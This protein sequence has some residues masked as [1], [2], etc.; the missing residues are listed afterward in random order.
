M[1]TCREAE[2]AE[3]GRGV[4]IIQGCVQGERETGRGQRIR[5]ACR[6]QAELSEVLK[7]IFQCVLKF[8]LRNYDQ[9]SSS[10]VGGG[11]GGSGGRRGREWEGESGGTRGR[12]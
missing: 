9:V 10:R 4:Y 5:G 3:G 7:P 11:E 6:D 8:A 1:L 2:G 12:E